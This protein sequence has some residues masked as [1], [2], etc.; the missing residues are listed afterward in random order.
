M[1]GV[2]M[3]MRVLVNTAAGTLEGSIEGEVQ[4]E[5]KHYLIMKRS[6]GGFIDGIFTPYLVVS[7]S[8][9]ERNVECVRVKDEENQ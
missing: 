4:L 8:I 6:K 2:S 5:G 1:G 3:G 7:P 9:L